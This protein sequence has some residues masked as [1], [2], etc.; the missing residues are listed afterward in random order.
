MDRQT[1]G[2]MPALQGA[3]AHTTNGAARRQAPP[4]DSVD[5]V[6]QALEGQQ[7]VADRGLATAIFLSLRLP[8]P[9]L[10]E[11]EAGV[12]KT[13]VAKTLAAITG[14]RLIRLQCYEGLDVAHAVYEWDYSRQMLHIRLLEASGGAREAAPADLFGPKFLIKRPLLQAIE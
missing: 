14:A 11:G 1:V 6:A 3:A 13:E 5:G 12:G 2:T 4:L 7:Y 9:L 8:K 10:L